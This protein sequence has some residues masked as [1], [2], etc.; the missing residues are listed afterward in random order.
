MGTAFGDAKTT[1]GYVGLTVNGTSSADDMLTNATELNIISY[2][3][4]SA[5][6]GVCAYDIVDNNAT[7][8]PTILNSIG[9]QFRQPAGTTT[10][11][12]QS[13]STTIVNLIGSHT[14]SKATSGT[15]P[16]TSGTPQALNV[17]AGQ[18]GL[19][20]GGSCT[21]PTLL[22]N[23]PAGYGGAVEILTTG[24]A[25]VSLQ[26]TSTPILASGTGILT[27]LYRVT[28]NMTHVSASVAGTL[29]LTYTDNTS[30]AT[31]TQSYTIVAAGAG[32]SVSTFF[33][34]NVKTG[35]ALSLVGT[36]ATNS[37]IQATAF[38]EQL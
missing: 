31:A 20:L 24:I 28:V 22:V 23:A 17:Y 10:G 33:M 12:I 27:G 21:I 16:I 37:D 7:T 6:G 26:S 36:S 3:N 15:P 30:G 35:T 5:V 38:I 34:A 19:Q 8:L 18:N 9:A 14:F 29:S 2:H 25:A 13:R 11:F 32:V 1:T 4:G